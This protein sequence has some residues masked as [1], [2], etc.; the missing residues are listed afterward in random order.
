VTAPPFIRR[1]KISRRR[2]RRIK[3]KTLATI[4]VVA[5]SSFLLGSGTIQVSS[6][7]SCKNNP[8][9]INVAVSSD[10][11]PAISRI[12]TVFNNQE[13][14]A[15]GRCVAV[16]VNAGSPAVQTAQI[17]GAAAANGQPVGDV[18]SAWIPDSSLWVD[19]ARR[20]P[21]GTQTVQP[22]GFS[23]A[24]SPLMLVMPMTA[25]RHLDAFAKAGWRLLL[26]PQAGG[27]PQPSGFRVF[28]PDPTQNAA[29]LATLVE[30]GRLLGA[31]PAAG[32]RFARF[33]FAASVTPYFDDPF[34]LASFVGLAGPPF[35]ALPVTVTSEQA[36]LA[37]D[38]AN[39]RQPLAATYP[40]G[41]SQALGAPELDYP[42][43]VTATDQLRI[44]AAT[45]FGQMLRTPFAADV[46]RWYGFRAADGVP[47]RF[48]ASF[49]LN[50]QLL[51]LASAASPT[52]APTALQVWNRLVLSSRDLA[53]V[54]LSSAMNRLSGPGGMT[55]EKELTTTATLGLRLFPDAA[56]IGLWV[57]PSNENPSV[58]Y[59]QLVSVGPLPQVEGVISR[60]SELERINGSLTP[61]TSA[62]APLYGAVL[63]AYKY[64]LSTWKPG[65]FNSVIVMTSG[66]E[67]APG[68]ISAPALIS[69]LLALHNPNRPV[70][71][72]L[73]VVGSPPDFTELQRIAEA[74]GGRA[75]LISNPSEVGQ[76][77][78]E[79]I[80]HRLCATSC[81][82]A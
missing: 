76:V 68:D 44:A 53:L 15:K 64:M 33:A 52:E 47:D 45:L 9:L 24:R 59:K 66:I 25:A 23:V 62:R 10:I 32:S 6:R 74:T 7:L 3:T 38:E 78:Y 30:M 28:L 42:Y 51:Q 21:V 49:G 40:A 19:Q 50:S 71:V 72:N 12:A 8:L 65:Y 35:S 39:P 31:G 43:A 81:V 69:K 36:V 11:A 57:Y 41:S 4:A 16:F 58:T 22:A 14:L 56:N 82:R 20:F 67:N 29:G 61:S 34:S 80:S 70:I 54:D 17:D 13:H 2:R 79:A 18:T 26:P 75:Y 46:I 37:Y 27:P 48:P 5:C 77:F 63:D 55:L 73:V 60:R 1:S